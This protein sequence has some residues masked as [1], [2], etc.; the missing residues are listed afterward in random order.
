MTPCATIPINFLSAS[1]P[2]LHPETVPTNPLCIHDC[3]ASSGHYV[4][5]ANRLD[6]DP[7]NERP[8]VY[9]PHRLAKSPTKWSLSILHQV[10]SLQK[11]HPFLICWPVTQTKS[12]SAHDTERQRL[13]S[14][15]QARNLGQIWGSILLHSLFQRNN[16]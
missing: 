2:M 9:K 12:C 11:L 16:W 10:G 8:L 1:T 13:H 7:A 15:L 3:K 4:V 6:V 14:K 5:W